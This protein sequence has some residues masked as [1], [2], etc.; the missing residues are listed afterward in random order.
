MKLGPEQCSAVLAGGVDDLGGTLMEETISRMAGSAHG[1]RKS[2]LELETMVRAAGRT[3]RQ[4]TT[5]YGVVPDERLAAARRERAVL[6][7]V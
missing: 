4:R 7:L 6:P 1:S 5:G 3:P 2:V